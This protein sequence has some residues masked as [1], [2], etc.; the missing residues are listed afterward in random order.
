MRGE[1]CGHDEAASGLRGRAQARREADDPFGAGWRET[2]LRA[3]AS[4]PFALEK[5]PAIGIGENL[6]SVGRLQPAAD[7]R[8]QSGGQHVRAPRRDVDACGRKG[9]AHGV[10]SLVEE[11]DGARLG[12]GG[13]SFKAVG[14]PRLRVVVL[15]DPPVAVR[16]DALCDM[17]SGAMARDPILPGPRGVSLRPGPVW[18]SGRIG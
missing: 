5:H 18:A 14:V 7:F 9:I 4:E 6:Q 12:A 10:A 13:L 17:R 15:R 2:K 3:C 8:A 11:R 16:P 1:F